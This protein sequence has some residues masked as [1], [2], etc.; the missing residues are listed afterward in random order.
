MQRPVR[1]GVAERP[2]PELLR[3]VDRET[4]VHHRLDLHTG[5]PRSAIIVD[6][7]P[8][9]CGLVRAYSLEAA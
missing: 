2:G 9:R 3:E 4:R 8:W 5:G 6:A 7:G 1:L